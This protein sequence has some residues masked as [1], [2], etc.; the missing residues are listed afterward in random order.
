[1]GCGALLKHR[2][3]WRM[4][5]HRFYQAYLDLDGVLN[6]DDIRERWRALGS[7]RGPLG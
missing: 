7:R 6:D 3:L 1:V 2:G 4:E 5:A